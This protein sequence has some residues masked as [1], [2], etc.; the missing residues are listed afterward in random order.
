MVRW[1]LIC[2]TAGNQFSIRHIH[3]DRIP[4]WCPPSPREGDWFVLATDSEILAQA[5]DD[6]R[7]DDERGRR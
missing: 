3:E 5:I 2:M 1:A 6:A 4:A 7:K